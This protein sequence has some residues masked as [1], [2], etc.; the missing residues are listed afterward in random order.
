VAYD[1]LGVCDLSVHLTLAHT[2]HL[3]K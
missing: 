1:L 3:R 2:K